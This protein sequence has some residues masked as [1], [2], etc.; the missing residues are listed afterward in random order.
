AE[1]A[2]FPG[3]R[4]PGRVQAILPTAQS[5]SRTV[6]VRVELRNP[7]LR[8]RPGMF[9]RVALGEGERSAL[10]I[11]T[12]AVIRTGKRTLVMLAAG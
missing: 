8:L 1:L 7:G 2:A 6:T 12:E 4:F 11:P 9:A 3:E 10:L 5:D